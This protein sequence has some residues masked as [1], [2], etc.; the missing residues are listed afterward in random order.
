MTGVASPAKE[1]EVQIPLK[2][3]PFD[4]DQL[5]QPFL[6]GEDLFGI[7]GG[8]PWPPSGDPAA[9][10]PSGDPGPWSPSSKPPDWPSGGGDPGTGSPQGGD[11]GASFS[12]LTHGFEDNFVELWQ[13]NNAPS[14][15]TDPGVGTSPGSVFDTA[16]LD[17]Q[18]E[19]T[20]TL[21][22]DNDPVFRTVSGMS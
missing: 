16:P 10:T 12:D 1:C 19:F 7:S 2:R 8:E 17:L 11:Q 5:T 15:S 4:K 6:S 21:E 14:K 13:S 3:D 22:E 20:F 9:W 18:Q